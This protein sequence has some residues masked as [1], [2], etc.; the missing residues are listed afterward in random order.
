MLIL[1]GFSE[2]KSFLAPE[3]LGRFTAKDAKVDLQMRKQDFFGRLAF[4]R[5]V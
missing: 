5:W 2:K 4:R 1:K 3:E